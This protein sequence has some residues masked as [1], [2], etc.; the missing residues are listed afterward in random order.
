MTT[1]TP[2]EITLPAEVGQV[3]AARVSRGDRHLIV[4]VSP[5]PGDLDPEDYRFYVCG[6]G[7]DATCTLDVVEPATGPTTYVEDIHD[8]SAATGLIWYTT[9]E[10]GGPSQ[11]VLHG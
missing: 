8:I 3:V 1:M 4:E 10:I 11:T 9:Q 5:P 2:H 6:L 7:P